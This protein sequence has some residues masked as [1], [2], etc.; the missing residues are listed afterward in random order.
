M[1]LA[2]LAGSVLLHAGLG[3]LALWIP[4][5]PEPP[6]RRRAPEVELIWLDQVPSPSPAVEVETPVEPSRSSEESD[7]SQRPASSAATPEPASSPKPRRRA[8]LASP[9]P[10][11]GPEPQTPSAPAGGGL[12]LGGLRGASSAERSSGAPVPTVPRPADV[13]PKKRA[14]A[15]EGPA[16]PPEDWEPRTLEEAGFR[17]RKDGSYR[18]W[19]LRDVFTVKIHPSGRIEFRDRALSVQDTQSGHGGSLAMKLAGE[20]RFKR[21]KAQVVRQTFE[22]R[23]D[24]ARTW[25]R[26]Q[27]RKQLAALGRQLD[28]VWTREEWTAVRRR[29]V[30]FTLWDDCEEAPEGGVKTRESVDDT[31]DEARIEAGTK[32]RKTILAFIRDELPVDSADAYSAAELKRLNASRTSRQRFVPYP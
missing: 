11:Q 3:V 19:R 22:L 26:G 28:Q 10:A 12:A 27:M 20:E 31:L 9:E 7:T 13:T 29:K 23:M 32:A 15:P 24:M 25:S 16:L 17:K 4:T 14:A 2:T 21:L 18:L 1:R 30:L 6:P 8:P 5:S